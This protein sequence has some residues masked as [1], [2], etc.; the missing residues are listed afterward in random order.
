MLAVYPAVVCRA[1][2]G[3]EQRS[4]QKRPQSGVVLQ[5]TRG[6]KTFKIHNNFSIYVT[7]K[8]KEYISHHEEKKHSMSTPFDK[9][10]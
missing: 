1:S 7:K 10:C 2:W 4:V 6:Q 5:L 8:G 9:F 3:G